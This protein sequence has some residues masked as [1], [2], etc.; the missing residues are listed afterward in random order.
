M[1]AWIALAR[2]LGLAT[3]SGVIAGIVVGGLL[4]R[5]VM[6]I[7]GFAA[8]PS[9]VGVRTEA[10]NPV[11]DITVAGTLALVLFVGIPAG[12]VGGVV[13]GIV[14]P[15]L[16]RLRPWHGLAYGIGLLATVGF[17][18]LD[19]F[20]FDFNRFG[21]P[22]L[23]LAMFAALF[24]IFGVVTAWLFD[25]LRRLTATAGTT[26]RVVDVLGLLSLGPA[27]LLVASA[28]VGGVQASTGN[29]PVAL[30]IIGA[31]AV[32]AIVRLLGLPRPLGY[33][34]LA[35]ALLFGATRTVDSV[36]HVLYGF[37]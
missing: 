21:P 9:M 10:G 27:A 31:L 23:N 28:V 7:S 32:A 34:G 6:R 8:G 2:H 18:V 14:E 4:G 25:R 29:T 11:G 13:Y 17:T 15:W 36:L 22:P 20:N 30:V 33:A 19:P 3:L 12:L 26:A 37:R 5:V 16:R 1:P 24:V 35:G